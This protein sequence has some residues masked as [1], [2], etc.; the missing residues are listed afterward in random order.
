MKIS[1]LEKVKLAFSDDLPSTFFGKQRQISLVLL[2]S[3]RYRCRLINSSKLRCCSI[4]S[5]DF[6]SGGVKVPDVMSL[7]PGVMSEY[8]HPV[9]IARSNMFKISKIKS[10]FTIY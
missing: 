5:A 4:S 10:N 7:Y 9:F 6:I 2:H 3:D 8:H 1:E